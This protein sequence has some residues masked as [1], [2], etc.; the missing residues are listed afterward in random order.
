MGSLLQSLFSLFYYKAISLSV[1]VEH[2]IYVSVRR[3][4][5][6]ATF[7]ELSLVCF[8]HSS[9]DEVFYARVSGL[10]FIHAF[11]TSFTAAFHALLFCTAAVTEDPV[12]ATRPESSSVLW[13]VTAQCQS[14][15]K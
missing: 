1:G 10:R 8:S 3:Y 9:H 13:R 12:F 15:W 11:I 6:F 7:Y 4:P 2:I 14:D 5:C